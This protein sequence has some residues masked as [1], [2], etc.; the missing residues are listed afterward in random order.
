MQKFAKKQQNSALKLHIWAP[1]GTKKQCTSRQFSNFAILCER[2]EYWTDNTQDLCLSQLF[3]F[4]LRTLFSRASAPFASLRGN[5]ATVTRDNETGVKKRRRYAASKKRK[6]EGREPFG[7]DVS[8]PESR[9]RPVDSC[10]T[11]VSGPRDDI[12]CREGL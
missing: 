3:A 12:G 9:H 2:E 1:N 7:T 5:T 10:L 4:P 6:K 11:D 8:S